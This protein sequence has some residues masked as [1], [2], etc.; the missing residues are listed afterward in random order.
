MHVQVKN[1]KYALQYL[2][3]SISCFTLADTD[4]I[5]CLLK[6]IKKETTNPISFISLVLFFY[7]HN[8]LHLERN[9]THLRKCFYMK[10]KSNTG[11]DLRNIHVICHSF[12]FFLKTHNIRHSD[13][14]IFS[15]SLDGDWYVCWFIHLEFKANMKFP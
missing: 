11:I 2:P 15:L 6:K 8:N 3:S 7:A 12:F 9:L 4:P 5:L 14:C 1:L 13:K 10:N